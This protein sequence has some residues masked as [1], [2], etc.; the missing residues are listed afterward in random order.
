M[1]GLSNSRQR[2]VGNCSAGLQVVVLAD[3]NHS[4]GLH[5]SYFLGVEVVLVDNILP[6]CCHHCV[7]ELGSSHSWG[8]RG[9]KGLA[10]ELVILFPVAHEETPAELILTGS[11]HG[12]IHQM[13][14]VEEEPLSF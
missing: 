9:G 10:L 7:E 14:V 11:G 8:R 3:S 1:E 6:S 13:T 2:V 5:D 4:W 12:R